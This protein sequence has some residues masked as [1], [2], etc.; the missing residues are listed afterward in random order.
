[1]ATIPTV[2]SCGTSR[3]RGYHTGL[4]KAAPDTMPLW[5]LVCSPVSVDDRP[6]SGAR[7]LSKS[8]QV[9]KLPNTRSVPP[10]KRPPL[11]HVS[12]EEDGWV[13]VAGSH[14][15]PHLTPLLRVTRGNPV[16]GCV[17]YIQCVCCVSLRPSPF[18][19]ACPPRYRLTGGS[20]RVLVVA[21]SWF[22]V[23]AGVGAKGGP[24]RPA[25]H[26]AL[27]HACSFILASGGATYRGHTLSC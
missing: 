12:T 27:A 1:M 9:Q 16:R 14:S 8:P 4:A 26:R 17:V 25:H 3:I 20:L 7:R 6:V 15:Y 24:P 23:E 18:A 10:S 22:R 5:A 21:S 11:C 2:E 13:C 19:L